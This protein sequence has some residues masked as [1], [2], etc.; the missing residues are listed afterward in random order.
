M[1]LTCDHSST[2][3]PAHDHD[4]MITMAGDDELETCFMLGKNTGGDNQ[5][6]GVL[7]TLVHHC[8]HHISCWVASM[9]AGSAV[10]MVAVVL[11]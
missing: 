4:E 11:M 3:G 1:I 8:H 2:L 10:D 7:Q 9:V 6:A 5:H